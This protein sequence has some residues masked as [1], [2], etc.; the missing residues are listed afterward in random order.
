MDTAFE[1]ATRNVKNLT[2]V[3]NDDKLAF[4]GFYKQAKFGPCNTGQPWFNPVE[5]AKWS[6]WKKLGGMSKDD[7]MKAYVNLYQQKLKSHT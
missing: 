4:Y 1:S 5:Q 6:A 2:G 7:A 3:S